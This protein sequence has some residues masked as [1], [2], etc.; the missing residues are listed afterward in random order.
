MPTVFELR[1]LFGS[2]LFHFLSKEVQ[3]WKTLTN[4]I[5][6]LPLTIKEDTIQL[7]ACQTLIGMQPTNGSY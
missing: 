5:D 6:I 3:A 7:I 1:L 2:L 4:S